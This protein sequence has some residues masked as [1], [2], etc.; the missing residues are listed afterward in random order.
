MNTVL[1]QQVQPDSL[2]SQLL[3]AFI[4]SSGYEPRSIYIPS[5]ISNNATQKFCLAFDKHLNKGQRKNND[6]F[7]HKNGFRILR[8]SGDSISEINKVLS[9]VL[10][11]EK[12]EI[13]IAIDYSSM[14]RVWYGYVLEKLAHLQL[15]K[16]VNI[17]FC[18]S[19]GKY[20]KPPNLEVYHNDVSPIDGYYTISTPIKPIALIISLGYIKQQ[21]FSLSEFFDAE[22]Y[23]FLNKTRED[24]PYFI[25]V[26][27]ANEEIIKAT[28]EENIFT[29]SLNN[30]LF[31][32]TVLE[33]LCRDLL[34]NHKVIIAPC[35]PKPFTLISFLLSLK[36]NGVDVWRISFGKNDLTL[37]YEASGEIVTYKVTFSPAKVTT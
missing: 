17:F 35:G 11:L 16:T 19:K 7:F 29:Y 31:S 25:E 30:M 26:K 37:P 18:Y 13:N 1:S 23:L 4:G 3:D 12:D 6:Y 10:D 14:T 24:D 33:H 21:A 9:D 27:G 22:R 20:I 34:T 8:T 28:P 2:Q 32:E 5:L 15:T 36:L